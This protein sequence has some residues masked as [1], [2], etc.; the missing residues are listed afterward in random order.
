MK[1]K[2]KYQHFLRAC[3]LI[4]TV[5]FFTLQAQASPLHVFAAVAVTYKTAYETATF[6]G[7]DR[8]G[9]WL[10]QKASEI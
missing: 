4:C 1:M 3:I 9:K 7:A 2:T 8:F 10:G 5:T 6:F